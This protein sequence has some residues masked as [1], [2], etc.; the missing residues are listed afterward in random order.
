MSAKTE[1]AYLKESEY[2]EWNK[3]VSNS[4]GGSIYSTPEYLDILCGVTNGSFKI[5]AARQ[6]DKITGGIG[7]FIQKSTREEYV[8]PRLLLY[9][10]GIVL[11]DYDTL[12]HSKSVSRQIVTLTALEEALSKEKYSIH[13]RNR[14]SFYDARVFLSQKWTSRLSYTYTV[15][16]DDIDKLWNKVDPNQR[17]LIKRSEKQG[18]SIVK[19]E[20][21]QAFY[22]LH[23]D[24][25]ERKGSPIYLSYEN[26]KVYYERLRAKNLCSLY[27][28]CNQ[29][30][31]PV[32][33]QLVLLGP[34]PVTHT[35]C[36]ATD[37]SYLNS[38]VSAFIRWK[39]FEDLSKQGY[40]ANDLTD[41]ALNPVTRFKS[42]LGGDIQLCIELIK[43]TSTNLRMDQLLVK[44]LKK[45]LKRII[46]LR[47]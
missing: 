14:N 8:S 26:Y 32:S 17:R 13:F 42:Q 18:F 5:L 38:G 28:A 44:K 41:A 34:H 45:T 43:P 33:S 23:V 15:N 2:G 12:Y 36:A 21:F 1:T 40:A 3:F 4:S 19:D 25:H 11:Q 24:T 7:L 16:I 37:E 22:N 46:Y 35:V 6:G 31:Q 10:N 29:E 9:Y 39:V 20:D 30:G 47:Q 27:H